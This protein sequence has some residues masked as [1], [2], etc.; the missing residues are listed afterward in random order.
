[1]KVITLFENRTISEEYISKHGL[2]LYIETANHKILFDTGVD[3]SFIYNASKL[4]VNLEEIDIAI[5][6]HGHYDHGGGLEGFL[7]INSKAKIYIGKSAFDN[8]I[9]IIEGN[10]KHDI[11]LNKKLLPNSRFIFVDKI[12]KIDDELILFA[13]IKGKKLVPIGNDKL[14]KE[15]SNGLVEKDNFEHEINLLINENQKYSLICGCAHK[16]IVNIIECANDIV[17][18]H[19]KIVIGGFHLKGMDFSSSRDTA[20]LDELATLLSS[21]GVEKYY[22]CHCTGEEAYSYLDEKIKNLNELKTG[23]IID[24]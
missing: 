5:I 17:A 18:S 9:K 10:V 14:L 12:I 1:M 11:G 8:H 20:F 6:S 23:M 22:T 24:L 7:K 4:G 21:N 13:D 19:L 16:G 15:D 2:S 3:D